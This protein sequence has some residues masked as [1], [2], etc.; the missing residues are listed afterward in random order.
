MGGTLMLFLLGSVIVA[1]VVVL[2][3]NGNPDG[4]GNPLFFTSSPSM[5]P[6]SSPSVSIEP[7]AS[8]SHSFKT[9][10]AQLIQSR[11][12]ETNFSSDATNA[13]LDWIVNDVYSSRPL[14]ADRLLQ[15]FALA[16]AWFALG[17]RHSTGCGMDH[18]MQPLDEC[19]WR[20]QTNTNTMFCD[21]GGVV[22]RLDVI[23]SNATGSIPT[24][25]FLL[26]HLRYLGL[27]NSKSLTG[28][29]P[30]HLALLTALT[31]LRIGPGALIG[32]ILHTSF[33]IVAH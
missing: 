3:A 17:L 32:T 1:V 22:L 21:S 29:I 7:T 31:E 25:L 15:R 2:V 6:S 9:H 20:G 27:E 23:D 26:S 8:P 30:S 19:D 33:G 16:T 14:E 24:E 28:T 13:A 12:P 4:D 10:M 11:S 18:W 5:S